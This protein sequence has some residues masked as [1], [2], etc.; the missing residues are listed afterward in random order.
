MQLFSCIYSLLFIRKLTFNYGKDCYLNR[1][2]TVLPLCS[3]F[4]GEIWVLH[5][6]SS[7]F[8]LQGRGL[9]P[10]LFFLQVPSSGERFGFCTVHPP[11]SF[12]RGEVWVLHCSSSRFLLQ[13]RGLGPALFFLQVPSSG[14]RFGF[15][16]VLP[17]GSFFRGEV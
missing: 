13:G 6:S 4:R 9:G 17:P 1:S 14:E 5:C 8:L 7:R 10:A 3:F 2:C 15:C 12:F 11:G 16:T